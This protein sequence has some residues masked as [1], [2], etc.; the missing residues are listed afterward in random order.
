MNAKDRTAYLF[1]SLLQARVGA[2]VI[3]RLGDRDALTRVLEA[4]AGELSEWTT[5]LSEKAARAFEELKQGFDP[6]V[7][8]N[9]LASVGVEVLTLADESYP[10]R[11]REVPDPPPALF[12]KGEVSDATSVA[13]VGS[14]RASATGIESSRALGRALGERGVCVVSGLAVGI[15]AAAHEGAVDAGAETVGVLG[16]GIDVVYPRENGRLFDSVRRNGA[17]VSE[18]G[19]GEA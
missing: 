3:S 8:L 10:A 4:P 13:L 9:S 7:V 19:Q 15:D 5:S 1:L 6:Q 17:V 18:Y 2:S 14:R 16:C 12:V 11:L